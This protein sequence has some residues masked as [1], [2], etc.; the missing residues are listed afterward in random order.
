[1]NKVNGAVGLLWTGNLHVCQSAVETVLRGGVL[2]PMPELF[3]GSPAPGSEVNDIDLFRSQ[4]LNSRRYKSCKR[5]ERD[6]VER[7]GQAND[8]NLRL[9]SSLPTIVMTG[10]RMK[11]RSETQS[12]E[13]ETTTLESGSACNRSLQGQGAAE[14]KL[15]RLFI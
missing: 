7:L 9:T 11:R 2:C 10:G 3:V 15:L 12:E 5:E 14:R 8:L 13:S 1:M 4:D 6:D